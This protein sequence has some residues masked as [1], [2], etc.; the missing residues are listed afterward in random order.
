MA[1]NATEANTATTPASSKHLVFPTKSCKSS[2]KDIEETL[3]TIGDITGS[4]DPAVL[5]S[6]VSSV[7]GLAYWRV[8]CTAAQAIEIDELTTV[9]EVLKNGID[10][11]FVYD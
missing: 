4:T 8:T 7:T 11:N 10:P 2:P 3:S 6:F 5:S 1:T 9:A